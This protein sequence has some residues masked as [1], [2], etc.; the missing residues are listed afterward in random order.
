VKGILASGA[1]A[2]NCKKFEMS[3]DAESS[4]FEVAE[5]YMIRPLILQRP[6]EAFHGSIVVAATR[7]TH[8][9][10]DAEIFQ[11]ALV[12]VAGVLAASIAVMQEP[13]PN[14]LPSFS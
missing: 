9:A 3:K 5:R 8:R 10:F 6:E 7:A 2:G 1:G 14:R 13:S 4:V 12:G 11:Q